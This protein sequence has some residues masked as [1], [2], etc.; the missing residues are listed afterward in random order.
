M[1]DDDMNA[2]P[3]ILVIFGVFGGVALFVVIGSGV[4]YRRDVRRQRCQHRKDHA[5]L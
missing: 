3:V 2:T 4:S 1:S 5:E